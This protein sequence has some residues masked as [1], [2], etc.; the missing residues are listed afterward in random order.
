[1]VWKSRRQWP[2]GGVGG[3]GTAASRPAHTRCGSAK[4]TAP[5]R[6]TTR[7]ANSTLATATRRVLADFNGDG[8]TD[9]LWDS[10]TGTDTRSTGTRFLWL[11]DGATPDVMTSVTTGIGAN[12]AITYKSLTDAGVYTKDA[13]AI[14]PILDLQGAMYVVSRVDAGNGIGGTLSSTAT[15]MPAPRPTRTAAASSASAR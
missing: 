15:P 11:I 3:T 6:S 13:T 2:D 7:R 14:D 9:I 1:M 8:K 5:S 12:A 4:A 10:R